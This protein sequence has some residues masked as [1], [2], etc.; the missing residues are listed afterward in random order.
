MLKARLQAAELVAADFIVAEKAADSA[1]MLAA[2][3]VATMLKAR[4]DAGLPVA[5]GTRA[6]QLVSDAA[7][8]LVRA[9]QRLVEAHGALVEA[10][11]A[12]GLRGFL[13]YGD[14][15]NC[16]DPFTTGFAGKDRSAPKLAVV[17]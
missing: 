4:V 16:D 15:D 8:D 2:T 7:A 13:N 11:D 12:I 1:A 17:A 14:E 10:R 9:R 3:C 6:L 5:T